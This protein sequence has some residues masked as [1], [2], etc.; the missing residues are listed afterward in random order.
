M[1]CLEEKSRRFVLMGAREA[2]QGL[3]LPFENSCFAFLIAFPFRWNGGDEAIVKCEWNIN[4]QFLI[5]FVEGEKRVVLI[6]EV[7][8]RSDLS[9][10]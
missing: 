7:F 10:E 1:L 9:L 2:E 8:N 3:K 4:V 6:K 5:E